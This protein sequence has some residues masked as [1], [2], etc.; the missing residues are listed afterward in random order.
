MSRPC[1]VSDVFIGTNLMWPED[2]S[3]ADM[4]SKETFEK[5]AKGQKKHISIDDLFELVDSF[6]FRPERIAYYLQ[7]FDGDR[8]K[9][10]QEYFD[11]QDA[12]Q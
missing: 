7:K 11:A 4:I 6:N 1:K 9:A 2:L 8:G 10:T 3:G 12:K 5:W